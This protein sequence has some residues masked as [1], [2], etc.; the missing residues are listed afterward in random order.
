MSVRLFRVWMVPVA[1]ALAC[2]ARPD[3]PAPQRAFYSWRTTWEPS[4]AQQDALTRLDARRL[5]VRAFDVVYDAR[6]ARPVARL[7]A[8]NGDR[9]P[10]GVEIVPVVF[11]R[12]DVFRHPEPGLAGHVLAEIRALE[13]S[14]G[15]TAAEVQVDCDWTEATRD[16][17][18]GFVRELRASLDVP[19]SATI[20]LHQ[21]KYRERTGVPPVD[22]GMLM[23]YNMGT[24]GPSPAD[25]AIFDAAA[26]ERYLAR[27]PSYPLP[28]DVALPLFS[29][30][31]H[32]RE[33]RVVALL[34]ETDPAELP[35]FDW[36]EPQPDGTFRAAR[37]A[38]LRGSVVREGDVLR[39]E[40]VDPAAA[41]AAA[42]LVAPALAPGARTVSLFDLSDAVLKRHDVESLD[43][44]FASVR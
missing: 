3:S 24:I 11:L 42:R 29:W 16:A 6:R 4:E 34:Q 8:P 10:A 37:S 9:L 31:V 19:L 21:V 20:R 36:L 39:P 7:T 26:A 12:E 15:V 38:F 43:A 41:L 17:F 28:L 40:I 13:T 25:R 27:L 23:F 18:F 5:Y 44:V 2:T 30:T 35:S 32:V 33:D 1:L 14:F 22:R